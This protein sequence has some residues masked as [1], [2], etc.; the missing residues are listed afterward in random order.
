MT[1]RTEARLARAFQLLSKCGSLL[2]HAEKEQELLAAVCRLAVEAGGYRMSWVGAVQHDDAKSIAPLAQCGFEDGYLESAQVSWGPTLRGTGP[3][4]TAVRTHRAVVVQDFLADPRTAP[5]HEAARQRGYQASISMPLLN[6]R[7]VVFGIFCIYAAEPFA[8]GAEEVDLLE[9]LASDLAYGIQTLRSREEHEAARLVLKRESEK[10]A[11]LLRNAS[12]GIHI[13][14]AT[15][16]LLEAS[17]S[18]CRMLGYSR[19]EM[20]G[21]NVAQWDARE[22]PQELRAT[23]ARQFNHK[24]RSLFET[25]HR[26]KDGTC[27]D[28]EVSGYPL[29]L[30]GN[31]VLFNSS[32][33]ITER[34]RAQDSLRESELR[35]R[36]IIEQSPV[37]MVFSRDGITLNVNAV[38]LE[39]FGIA[40]AEDVCGRPI[41]EQIAPQCRAEVEARYRR[42]LLS[43]AE[44]S[45]YESIGLRADGSQFP[46]QITAKRLLLKDGTLTLAFLTDIT[47]QRASE[48]EIRR[49]AFFDHLTDLP[50]RRLLLDRLQHAIAA[51]GRSGRHG[52]LLFIDLDNFKSLNDTLGHSV[53]DALLKQ[54]ALRLRASVRASDS[55]GRLGGDE[56]VVILE[57]LSTDLMEA[58][59]QTETASSKILAALRPTY[60]LASGEAHCTASLGATLFSG[61]SQSQDELLKQADIAMYQAK[62]A[63]RNELRFFDPRMQDAINAKATLEGELR[64]ALERRQ[65]ELRFQVQVDSA[66][67]TF[68]AESLIRWNHPERGM[69]SPLDFIPLAEETDLIVPIGQW[70]LETAC[71]QLKAWEAHPATQALT[72]CVNVS[73]R[74]F[75]RTDFVH[76][77]SSAVAAHAINPA[78][79][80]LEL[81]ESLLLEKVDETI[82]TMAAL[83]RIGVRFS[84]DDFGTGYSS[85]QYLKRL[86]LHQL[87]IDQSFVRDIAID[88]N[89]LAIVQTIIAM[90]R[91]LNLGVIA[92][93]VETEEQLRLL[94]S[95]GCD[96]FQGYLFGRPV[97]IA[98]FDAA[99]LQRAVT[100]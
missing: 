31:P 58:A 92:E 86:P 80:T 10:N 46:L 4:G 69:I 67:R 17:D 12:D 90:A 19:E 51:S 73:A 8:F 6:H 94:I 77:V 95:R 88:S 45:E 97:A 20:V 23:L 100:A 22:G 7:H 74:Q 1:D 33:D 63:G 91:S 75:H 93:G 3:T 36:A 42:R 70:V 52:A 59:Q 55:V 37:G 60:W 29:E 96:Q 21:M 82:A 34:K 53:G 48:D 49:L 50:N 2:V 5:W 39:M 64:Q 78:L 41:I 61:N 35:L 68:G 38:F 30:D 27:F 83:G 11:A 66:G 57:E 79:L 98:A 56:F 13:L 99:L 54:V 81:T 40:H 32:R 65:F 26:H 72:L 25:R 89:D 9:Q 85:L 76:S 71:A 47:R 24:E 43:D 18:F 28:V 44:P 87:K 62:R 84:L 14:D 16:K 15:G